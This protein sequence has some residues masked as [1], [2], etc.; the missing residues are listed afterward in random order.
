MLV[1]V[2]DKLLKALSRNVVDVYPAGN[3]LFHALE[4]A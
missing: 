2:R 4:L 3:H 1:L